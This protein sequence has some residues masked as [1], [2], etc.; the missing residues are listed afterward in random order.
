MGRLEQS[1]IICN[2]ICGNIYRGSRFGTQSNLLKGYCDVNV[3]IFSF[4]LFPKKF[5]IQ[6]LYLFLCTFSA[7]H[8]SSLHNSLGFLYVHKFSFR[9]SNQREFG[10]YFNSNYG[11]CLS[12]TFSHPVMLNMGTKFVYKL[13]SLAGLPWTLLNL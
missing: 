11:I 6:T 2:I 1:E 3:N 4:V 7:S 8:I 12:W 5:L 9:N 10:Y 13:L